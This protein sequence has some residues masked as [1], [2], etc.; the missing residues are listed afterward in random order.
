MKLAA[1]LI[2]LTIVACALLAANQRKP[3][4]LRI[5][6]QSPGV[7]PKYAAAD[8]CDIRTAPPVRPRGK[9]DYIPG[10]KPEG[11]IV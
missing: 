3:F 4:D 7:W 9:Y 2:F 8:L 1:V 5:D 10:A 11:G 6:A